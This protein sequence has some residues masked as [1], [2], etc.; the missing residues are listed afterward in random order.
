MW[1][2]V[3]FIL[4]FTFLVFPRV[5]AQI[6]GNPSGQELSDRIWA[7]IGIVRDFGNTVY[8]KGLN[9]VEKLLNGIIDMVAERIKKALNEKIDEEKEEIKKNIH[10]ETKD[11]LNYRLIPSLSIA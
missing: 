1:K 6:S 9:Q 10:E 3:S 11:L 5:S 7:V 2:L 4:I 8:N